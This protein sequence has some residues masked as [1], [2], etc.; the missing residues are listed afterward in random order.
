MDVPK[1]SF[2]DSTF[3]LL[4]DVDQSLRQMMP[5]LNQLTPY[6]A[7]LDIIVKKLAIARDNLLQIRQP[8]GNG[9]A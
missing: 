4:A 6:A 7:E 5:L 3:G 2:I 9:N 1:E 8:E